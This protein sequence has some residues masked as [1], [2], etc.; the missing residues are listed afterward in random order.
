MFGLLHG[1]LPDEHTW[2]ITF[3]YAVGGASGR[4][5]IKAGLFF[6][7]A[8]TVQRMLVSELSYFALAPIMRIWTLNA[9]VY[10]L[11]GL[12][13]LVAGVVVLRRG[14]YPHVHLL[15]HHHEGGAAAMEPASLVLGRHHQTQHSEVEQTPPAY[16]A[17]IHGFIAG[18]GF[19]A[20]SLFVNTVA[21]PAMPAW[22]IGFLPGFLFGLG[23]TT[24]LVVLGWFFG[25]SLRWLHGLDEA[26]IKRVGAMTGGRT[27]LYGG[28][29]Y[30]LF[31]VASALSPPDLRSWLTGRMLLAVFLLL[32]A[33]PALLISLREVRLPRH[34]AA[35]AGDCC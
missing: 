24:V 22:W 17:L 2:P 21:A 12:A 5:G 35:E 9:P 31:G 11:V 1:I 27:L 29:L 30:A 14:R 16:W 18:F 32:A 28:A 13:M 34:E 10:A 3:S 7:L 19:G 4:A 23:T 26:G 6:S 20:F 8:F 33:L 25:H 15:G